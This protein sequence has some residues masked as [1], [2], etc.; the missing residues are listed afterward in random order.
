[1]AR[2]RL[3]RSEDRKAIFTLL[4]ELASEIYQMPEDEAFKLY[5]ELYNVIKEYNKRISKPSD[6]YRVYVL[7]VNGRIVGLASIIK[8]RGWL[9]IDDLVISKE[10]RGKGYG[11]A[12]I[13]YLE[14]VY[15]NE[16]QYLEADTHERAVNFFRK[17]GFIELYR[18]R[19]EITWIKM[20]KVLR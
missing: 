10:Y 15:R 6:R 9:Y 17:L 5:D 13:N 4:K 2:I 12:L 11:K 1:M 3:A 14:K 20:I 16:C 19:K 7:E 8:G 18:F